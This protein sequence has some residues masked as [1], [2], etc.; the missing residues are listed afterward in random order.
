MNRDISKII[1]IDW[2][3]SSHHSQ[4]RN[5]L[6]RLAKWE[7]DENDTELVYLASFLKSNSQYVLQFSVQKREKNKIKCNQFKS[8]VI[9]SSGVSDVREVL[10]YYNQ[11]VNPLETFKLNQ[12]KL[13]VFCHHLIFCDQLLIIKRKRHFNRMVVAVAFIHLRRLKYNARKRSPSSRISKK[14]VHSRCLGADEN[15]KKKK[16][17]KTK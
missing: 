11:E 10:D 4:P 6:H 12:V 3:E 9:A 15:K 13:K 17:K 1:L 14:Q 5:A 7:G 8:I 16:K 2:D